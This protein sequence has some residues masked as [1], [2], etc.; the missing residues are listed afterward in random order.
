[1]NHNC[2]E[3]RIHHEEYDCYF[4]GICFKWLEE[5]CSDLTCEFCTKRTVP[6]ILYRTNGEL[7]SAL[8][9]FPLDASLRFITYS[10]YKRVF[11][12]PDENMVYVS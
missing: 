4:C 10:I 3:N 6:Y 2:Q 1:M 11:Y 7:I 12:D 9:K 5:K 8:R